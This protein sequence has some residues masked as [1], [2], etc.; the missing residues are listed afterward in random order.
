MPDEGLGIAGIGFQH[1]KAAVAGDI[2]DLEE[3]RTTLVSLASGLPILFPI[4]IFRHA[5][6]HTGMHKYRW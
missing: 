5:Y 6:A 2:G 3:I 4:T 1:F